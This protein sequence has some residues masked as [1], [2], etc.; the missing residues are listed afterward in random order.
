MKRG[1]IASVL[2]AIG[3]LSTHGG[4]GAQQA[5]PS[6]A[7][8]IILPFGAGGVA[9]ISTRLVAERLGERVGQRFIIENQPGAGGIN[10]ARSVLSASP[11][12]Y[13]LALLSNGTAISVGLFKALPFDP[14]KDFLPISS[15]AYFDFVFAVNA[16]SDIR[17][18]ADFLK[19]ARE[20]PGAL[21]VGT[22]NIGSSQHLSAVLFK[23]EAKVD[24][25]IVP[26]RGTPD[27]LV[28]LLRNDVHLVIDT[29]AAMKGQLDD[30]KIR[31]VATS[32]PKR[33]EATPDVPTVSEAGVS[34]FDV[35]SW[36]GLFVR[37]GTPP[38]V[39]D[40]LNR[41]MREVLAQPELKKRFLELG[42][43]AR[44][45]APAEL[46]QRLE[47]DIAKWSAV[48][49]RAGIPKN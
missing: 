30:K 16:G 17:S 26:F 43:E 46:R 3:A 6:K 10:A 49:E 34:G 12:G 39:I 20:R 28:A 4:A 1:L 11:D 8:R 38:A 41:H 44:A 23:T 33:S 36:N 31:A 40:T 5:Y 14:L 45:T 2:A 25:A 37:A 22:I 19:A 13:T 35:T 32:G 15:M 21:N 47:S 48:I 29:L 7:V 27:A 24:F 42:L 9:D 18:L